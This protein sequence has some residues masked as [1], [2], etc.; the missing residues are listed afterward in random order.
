MTS[1]GIILGAIV[2]YLLAVAM[3]TMTL[4]GIQNK[5]KKTLENE[6][7][8]LETLKNL[9]ISS[10]ILTEMEKV[11]ALINNEKLEK[12]YNAW[13]KRYHKI[14]ETS[15]PVLTDRLL[16]AESL[17]EDKKFKEAGYSLARAEEEIYYAK[18]MPNY[19]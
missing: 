5:N 9:I 4:F 12:K 2:I 15:I 6:L 11:K 1:S 7:S 3:I 10:G 13:E 14:E 17:I 8:R 16:E 18:Q 19:Y